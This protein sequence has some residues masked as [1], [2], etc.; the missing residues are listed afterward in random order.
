VRVSYALVETP[1][2]VRKGDDRNCNSLTACTMV[3]SGLITLFRLPQVLRNTAL[4]EGRE[5]AKWEK[6]ERRL[7][8]VEEE[9]TKMKKMMVNPPRLDVP[10]WLHSAV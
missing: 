7:T 6:L 1:T 5:A 3:L 10:H 9:N 8:L 2:R 4:M